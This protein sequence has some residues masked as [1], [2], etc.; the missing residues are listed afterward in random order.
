MS[1]KFYFCKICGKIITVVEEPG[2]PTVCCGEIMKELT[3]NTVD[4]ATE[5]HVP[6]VAIEGNRVK[7]TV[8]ETLHPMLEEHY[9]QWIVLETTK[10]IQKKKLKPNDKP[11]AEFML[12][13]DEKVVAAYEYCNLHKLWSKEL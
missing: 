7:V 3:P 2:T 9:I 1:V 11:E 6:V 13:D 5:K 12:L 4:A 8:G 10:G